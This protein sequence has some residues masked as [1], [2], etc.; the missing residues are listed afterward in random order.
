MRGLM[1]MGLTTEREARNVSGFFR[2]T[3]WNCMLGKE[4]MLEHVDYEV[5]TVPRVSR[6]L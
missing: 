1:R 2:V 3:N 6:G 4:E 5:L